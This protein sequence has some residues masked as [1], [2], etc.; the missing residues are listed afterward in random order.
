SD[1]GSGAPSP[2]EVPSL[3]L[4]DVSVA[5]DGRTA[6]AGLAFSTRGDRVLL[7]GAWSPLVAVIAGISESACLERGEL[8]LKGHPLGRHRAVSGVAPRALPLPP[9]LS[10]REY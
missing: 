8:I 4:R 10:L 1:E 2:A 5:I 6:L 9:R 7:V 3:S